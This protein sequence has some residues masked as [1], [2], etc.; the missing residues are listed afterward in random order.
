[1]WKD[2]EKKKQEKKICEQQQKED[3][4]TNRGNK[5]SDWR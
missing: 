1:M 4:R 3:M 5:E 2:S